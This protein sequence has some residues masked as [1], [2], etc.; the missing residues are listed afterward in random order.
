MSILQIQDHLPSACRLS[1][2]YDSDRR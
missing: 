2:S 1:K